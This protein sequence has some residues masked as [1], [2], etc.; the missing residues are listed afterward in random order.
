MQNILTSSIINTLVHSI[1]HLFM[2]YTCLADY[3]LWPVLGELCLN[4]S[5]GTK[6]FPFIDYY[7]QSNRLN[8]KKKRVKWEY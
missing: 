5:Q 7:N 3:D 8:S 1:A 2:W 4:K 6:K